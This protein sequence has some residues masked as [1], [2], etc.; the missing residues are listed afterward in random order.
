MKTKTICCPLLTKKFSKKVISNLLKG[1]FLLFFF[2][3]LFSTSTFAQN[4]CLI[5]GNAAS[6]PYPKAEIS[7]VTNGNQLQY[8]VTP[9]A[10]SSYLWTLTN[11]TS[12]ASLI[13]T[14]SPVAKINPGSSEG[15]FTLTCR[16][17]RIDDPSSVNTCTV[18]VAVKSQ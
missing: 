11:N 17:T 18:S 3:G 6:A 15:S 4:S 12:G 9:S 16:V 7:A 10:P 5:S 13:G 8:R 14:I 2:L 1:S